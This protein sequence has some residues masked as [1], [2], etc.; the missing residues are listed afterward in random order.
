MGC[1]LLAALIISVVR[2]AWYAL[3]GRT[4]RVVR[5]APAA[6]RPAPGLD[7]ATVSVTPTAAGHGRRIGWPLAVALTTVA[8]ALAV[9]GLTATGVLRTG[10]APNASLVGRDLGLTALIVTAALIAFGSR[11]PPVS[12]LD[13]AAVALSVAGALWTVLAIVDMH[14]LGA[15]DV[16]RHA[17]LADLLVHGTGL[18][19]LFSGLALLRAPR[20]LSLPSRQ[21]ALP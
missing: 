13:A 21:G 19:L 15:V 12:R 2:R 16:A 18:A 20:A 9:S 3:T 17:L 14:V 1:C 8:Y 5:F 11:R 6:S 4:P 7:A 10:S